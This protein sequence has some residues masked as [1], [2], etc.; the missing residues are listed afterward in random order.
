LFQRL[1][2]PLGS[3]SHIAH[4]RL[5]DVPLKASNRSARLWVCAKYIERHAATYVQP[6]N[7]PGRIVLTFGFS[8]FTGC[9]ASS[10]A[11]GSR[12]GT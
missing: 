9:G 4:Y 10:G 7:H 11:P 8:G 12:G 2:F 3:D 1:P 5:P 6:P